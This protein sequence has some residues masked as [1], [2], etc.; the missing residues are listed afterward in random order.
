MLHTPS[1]QYVWNIS[2]LFGQNNLAGLS[3]VTGD[4]KKGKNI[5]EEGRK[6]AFCSVQWRV[7]TSCNN[8]SI[9]FIIN[10]A[11]TQ[12]HYLRSEKKEKHG[13]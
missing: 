11:L 1:V 3:K 7:Y 12:N 13:P 8:L 5:R 2:L 10:D 6:C 9:E 4:K